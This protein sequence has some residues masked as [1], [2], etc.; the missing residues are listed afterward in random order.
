MIPIR[1]PSEA[2]VSRRMTSS[3]P[4]RISSEA[5]RKVDTARVASTVAHLSGLPPSRAI[6]FALSSRLSF[7]RCEM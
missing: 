6:S 3:S 4:L 7:N 5:H 1:E 2:S